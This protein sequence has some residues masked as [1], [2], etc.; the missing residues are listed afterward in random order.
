MALWLQGAIEEMG[1]EGEGCPYCPYQ[2]YLNRESFACEGIDRWRGYT[3]ATK[4][5]YLIAK[6]GYAS[7]LCKR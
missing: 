3:M 4:L 7:N 6:P 5:W 1:C 2:I